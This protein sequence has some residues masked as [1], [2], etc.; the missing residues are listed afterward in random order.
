MTVGHQEQQIVPHAVPPVLCRIEQLRHLARGQK[1]FGALV[2]IGGI[3]CAIL[4]TLT[5]AR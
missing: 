1:V 3:E 5:F 2:L 4:L